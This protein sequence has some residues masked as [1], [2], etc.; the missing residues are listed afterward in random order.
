MPVVFVHRFIFA[1]LS[2][3]GSVPSSMPAVRLLQFLRVN[4]YCVDNVARL[5]NPTIGDGFAHNALYATAS[6]W[7]TALESCQTKPA[8]N[9]SWNISHLGIDAATGYEAT[10]RR[11]YAGA[12][13]RR[14][15]RPAG[16]GPGTTK[17]AVFSSSSIADPLLS[18]E[19]CDEAC[20]EGQTQGPRADG[21]APR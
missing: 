7:P 3:F 5:A 10:G 19:T 8:C 12:P 6:Q 2:A 4:F 16:A 17:P 14:R 13:G 21:H 18:A 15:W 11:A 1:G 9:L 20:A